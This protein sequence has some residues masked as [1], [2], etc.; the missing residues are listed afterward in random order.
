MFYAL[1]ECARSRSIA[2]KLSVPSFHEMAISLPMA[3]MVVG[4]V[5]S[6]VRPLARF[7]AAA[8]N[9]IHKAIR[10]PAFG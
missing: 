7:G 5:M 2:M 9:C 10:N 6:V 1:G 3:A 8:M 4:R